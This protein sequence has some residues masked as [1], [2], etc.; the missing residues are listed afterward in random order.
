M[1]VGS[2][3]GGLLTHIPEAYGGSASDRQLVERSGLTRMCEPGDSIM[4]DKGF[5]VQDMFATK[6]VAI[7]IPTFITKRNR[8]PGMT[9]VKDRKISSK[10]VHIERLIGLAKT[11]KI[12]QEPM[13]ATETALGSEIVFICCMLC[14]FRT[15]IVPRNA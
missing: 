12:L 11:F 8:L 14:N 10:R 3:P 7:N 1:V 9:V 2:S 5:N 6:N 4:A 15:C 13:N